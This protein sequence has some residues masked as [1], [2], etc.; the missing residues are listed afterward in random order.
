MDIWSK[1]LKENSDYISNV[2]DE[3]S[4]FWKIIQHL[5]N[6]IIYIKNINCNVI[7][8]DAKEMYNLLTRY[9][10]LYFFIFIILSLILFCIYSFSLLYL[11]IYSIF[12]II[13]I[14]ILSFVALFVM[15]AISY[16]ISKRFNIEPLRHAIFMYLL[17]LSIVLW[18]NDLF[19]IIHKTVIFNFELIFLKKIYQP[20]LESIISYALIIVILRIKCPNEFKKL[21]E[22]LTRD[23]NNIQRRSAKIFRQNNLTLKRYR[24]IKM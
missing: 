8:K 3:I 19:I 1:N 9:F 12:W 2:R 7:Y 18:M 20:F 16:F 23:L 10:F 6:L 17:I 13:I 11:Q 21:R 15:M 4:L 24:R 14:V 5:K 22:Y